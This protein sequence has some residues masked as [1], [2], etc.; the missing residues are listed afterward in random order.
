MPEETETE[1]TE[2]PIFY[3]NSL[4]KIIRNDSLE[5][6]KNYLKEKEI[7]ITQLVENPKNPINASML[8]WA[9]LSKKTDLAEFLI[10]NGADIQNVATPK[11]IKP[12]QSAIMHKN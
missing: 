10:E 3:D 1:I 12:I 5:D 9:V 7:K 2:N 11:N 4:I 8:H 6:L